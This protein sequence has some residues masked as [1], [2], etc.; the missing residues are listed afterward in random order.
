MELIVLLII[1]IAVFLYVMIRGVIDEKRQKRNI[2][3]S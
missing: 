3:I 2:A 1:L